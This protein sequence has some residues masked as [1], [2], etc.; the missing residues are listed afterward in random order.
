MDEIQDKKPELAQ[1]SQILISLG[2]PYCL[3]TEPSKP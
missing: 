1:L 3:H 2:H